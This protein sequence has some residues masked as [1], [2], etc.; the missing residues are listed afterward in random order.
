[1]PAAALVVLAPDA[2]LAVLASA[3]TH[4]CASVQGRRVEPE[5]TG[6]ATVGCRRGWVWTV[7]GVAL[8]GV[9]I[10]LSPPSYGGFEGA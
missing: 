5:R 8:W 10:H 7:V 2:A 1:M 6:V 4:F 9:G 3:A